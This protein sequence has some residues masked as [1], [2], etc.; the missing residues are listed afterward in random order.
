[1]KNSEVNFEIV[2]RIS[3]KVLVD[4]EGKL[5]IF[6]G[7]KPNSIKNVLQDINDAIRQGTHII[8]QYQGLR[9]QIGKEK[10]LLPGEVQELSKVIKILQEVT[11]KFLEPQELSQAEQYSIRLSFQKCQAEI[12][13]VTNKFKAKAQTRLKQIPPLKNKKGGKSKKVPI[14]TSKATVDLFE[15]LNEIEEINW[16]IILRTRKLIEEKLRIERIFVLVYQRLGK[17]LK[18]LQEGVKN[19][20]LK[21]IVSEI[22][23]GKNNLLAGLLSIKVMPYL[24]RVRSREIQ[25]LAKLSKYLEEGRKDRIYRS[26]E[27]SIENAFKKIRPVVQERESR[28]RKKIKLNNQGKL[29]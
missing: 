14:E 18:E 7:E 27:R 5:R 20:R 11:A 8:D 3:R 26:I 15:R 2:Q 21:R 24:K 29:F 25:R 1:M 13:R 12:G 4:K 17:F 16:G 19:E 10:L 6:W 28:Q 23:G 9:V 22:S